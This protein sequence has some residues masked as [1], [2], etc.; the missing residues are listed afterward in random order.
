MDIEG[1]DSRVIIFF[2]AVG[3]LLALAFL[4]IYEWWMGLN[5]LK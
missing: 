5:P 2:S 1:I 4:K 3:I